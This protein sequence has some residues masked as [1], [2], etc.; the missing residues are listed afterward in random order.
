MLTLAPDPDQHQHGGTVPVGTVRDA[1]TSHLLD[2]GGLEPPE[3]M[4]R[5]IE[6]L[7]LVQAD[8]RLRVLIDR[9]PIPLYRILARNGYAHSTTARAD[10]RYAVLIWL[11]GHGIA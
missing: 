5:I 6:A 10:G 8:E 9:D 7:D 1:A 4:V 3:P 11:A 2:V